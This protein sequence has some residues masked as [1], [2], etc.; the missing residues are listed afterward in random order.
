MATAKDISGGL[1]QY[2]LPAKSGVNDSVFCFVSN[3]DDARGTRGARGHDCFREFHP[4]Y[5]AN[6]VVSLD[7]TFGILFRNVSGTRHV[8]L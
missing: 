3:S 2:S 4:I 7:Q 5:A 1:Q 8:S 6:G